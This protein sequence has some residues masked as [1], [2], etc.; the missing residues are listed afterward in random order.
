M[1]QFRNVAVEG[2][3]EIDKK[4]VKKLELANENLNIKLTKMKTEHQRLKDEN[5]SLKASNDN[6]IFI[7]EKLN[8][9]LKKATD[10]KRAK[11]DK[12]A[13]KKG[14]MESEVYE[15]QGLIK[16]D[17]HIGATGG[18]NFEVSAQNPVEEK[19]SKDEFG[20]DLSSIMIAPMEMD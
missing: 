7:N 3:Q 10:Q 13:S 9:A 4:Y 8:R 19:K 20:G 18:S 6:H 14:D 15:I 1:G 5:F 11:K 2:S 16:E 17:E 12:K